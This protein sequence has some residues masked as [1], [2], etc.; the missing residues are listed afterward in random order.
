MNSTNPNTTS[1]VRQ[2]QDLLN[3]VVRLFADLLS[4]A[5]ASSPMISDAMAFALAN[6]VEV[7]SGADFTELGSLQ[8]D[9]MEVMCA[10]RRDASLVDHQGLP[11]PLAQGPGLGTFQALC[12]SA[13]CEHH[14]GAILKA[15]LEFGAVTLDEHQMVVSLTPT[16]L[17]ARADGRGR[18]ATDGLLKQLQGY[19]QVLH[20]NVRSVSG[21][22]KPRFERACTVAVAIELEPIFAQHVR[23]RG[24]EFVDSIDEWLERNARRESPSNR[25]L[26]LGVGAYY[27]DL[28][29]RAEKS[30]R[31]ESR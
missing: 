29:L 3:D 28:G 18:L 30:Q 8:R 11:R 22:G 5:G 23:T 16:F 7:N 25:Y 19:L 1:T 27:I 4:A 13:A 20:R 6:A 14:S 9:C 15:L 24:Q 21:S 10:W 17:V 26:E 12:A 2:G 31:F